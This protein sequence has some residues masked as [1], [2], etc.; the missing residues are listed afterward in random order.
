MANSKPAKNGKGKVANNYRHPESESLMRADVGTQLQFKK[1]LP[2]KKYRYDHSLSWSL[3][4]NGQNFAR[5]KGKALDREILEA[6]TI[7]EAKAAASKLMAMSKLVLNRAGKAERLSFE[8][9]TLPLFIHERL[10][11]KA[12]LKTLKGHRC[13]KPQ[14]DRYVRSPRRSATPDL[15]A[16]IARLQAQGQGG[17]PDG[18]RRFTSS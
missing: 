7:E 5:E 8:V 9:P 11:T 10:F 16:S 13:D 2:H 3:E 6:K 15:R 14:T 1:K 12:I 4:W 18:P 17:Q